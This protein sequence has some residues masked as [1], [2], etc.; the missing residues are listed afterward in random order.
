MQSTRHDDDL[1]NVLDIVV[2]LPVLER[3]VLG[4]ISWGYTQVEIAVLLS[5][6]KN[7]VSQIKIRAKT[8]VLLELG[9]AG[10]EDGST[11]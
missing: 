11:T 10:N 1:E 8:A 7:T 6:R 3:A 5:L 9:R 2:K 4:L